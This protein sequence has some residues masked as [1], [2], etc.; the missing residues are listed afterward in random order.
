MSNFASE[1]TVPVERSRAEIEKL[2]TRYG[3]T[4][5]AFMN[6]P[7]R[8]M[9]LFEASGRRVM[10]EL[11]LVLFLAGRGGILTPELLRKWRKG[12][13]LGAFLLAAFLGVP[14]AAA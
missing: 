9:V 1:T 12:A 4:S 11:P 2:I 14:S 8:A 6:S 3:A 5:T 7:G 10:F 13:V